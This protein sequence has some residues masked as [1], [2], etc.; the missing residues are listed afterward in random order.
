MGGI[1]V[2]IESDQIFHFRQ[3]QF[4]SRGAFID[5]GVEYHADYS[6]QAP[7]AAMVLGDL[8]CADLD[9]DAYSQSI[10]MIK[11]LNPK[12]LVL[13]DVFD[14]KSISH[15]TREKK[16]YRAAQFS[17]GFLSLKDEIK[18]LV[19]RLNELADTADKIVIVKSNH[20]EF[21]DRYLED[22][23]YIKEP[24][25]YAYAA[26][27]VANMVQG[28]DPLQWACE[29]CG[30]EQPEK[31][32]WLRREDDFKIAG[33]QLGAHGDKGGNGAKGSTRLMESG[34]GDSISG[35]CLTLNHSVNVQRKGFMP[36]SDVKIGDMVLSYNP[37]TKSNEWTAVNNIVS[38]DYSGVMMEVG[39]NMWKQDVTMDHRMFTRNGDYVSITEAIKHIPLCEIPLT[40]GPAVSEQTVNLGEHEIRLLVAVCADGHIDKHGCVRFHLKKERKM[41]RLE[42][43][44]SWFGDSIEWS[45]RKSGSYSGFIRKSFNSYKI[46]ERYIDLS[47]KRLPDIFYSL[48]LEGKEILVNELPFWDGSHMSGNGRQFQT[49]K[50]DEARM[51]QSIVNELGYRSTLLRRIRGGSDKKRGIGKAYVVV[52]NTDRES[53]IVSKKRDGSI[54]KWQVVPRVVDGIPVACLS[55]D[56]L[57]FWVRNDETGQVSLTGN[58]HTPEILRSAWRVGTLSILNPDYTKGAPSSWFHCNAVLYPNGMRQ[59]INIINNGYKLRK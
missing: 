50:E 6:K 40:A 3:V 11:D 8:H 23:R 55:T 46:I 2:E 34:Y 30:L 13:H 42:R 52:Y 38:Y 29:D 18:S 45:S 56:L 16:V 44:L 1:V 43:I 57:N 36:I 14:G 54:T 4:N 28:K 58:C 31:F 24:Y 53:P 10:S 12:Y 48:S 35:H 51:V 19:E 33:I 7:A 17:Q 27:I 49:I 59:L 41:R 26:Q 22:G 15:W 32:M 9:E 47:S 37:I 39:H 5:F 21:L 20:D 25:N